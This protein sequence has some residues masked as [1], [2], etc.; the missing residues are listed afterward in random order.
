[1]CEEWDAVTICDIGLMN[2][3]N[4]E[5]NDRCESKCDEVINENERKKKKVDAIKVKVKAE[6]EK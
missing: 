5:V 6:D 3:N 2:N 4:E 1:M